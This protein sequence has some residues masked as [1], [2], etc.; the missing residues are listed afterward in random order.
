MEN[1]KR[2]TQ[3]ER[4]LRY[5]KEYG[6]ITQVEAMEHLGVMRLASRIV[7]LK[8][9][10]VAIYRQME[11]RLNRWKEPVTWAR[12]FLEEQNDEKNS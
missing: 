9:S 1:N 8:K 4:V 6:S 11:G 12:Y 5:M 2:P 7:E 10:G 3:V